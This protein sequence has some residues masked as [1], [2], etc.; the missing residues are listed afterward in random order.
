MNQKH[1]STPLE[2]KCVGSRQGNHLLT[3]TYTCLVSKVAKAQ[4]TKKQD[5]LD[6]ALF[7]LAMKKKNVICGLYRSVK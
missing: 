2:D 4:F 6:C 7:Y 3:D 5:P 1:S